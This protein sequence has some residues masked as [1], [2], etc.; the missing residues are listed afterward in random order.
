MFPA[1][2]KNKRAPACIPSNHHLAPSQSL[3]RPLRALSP[4]SASNIL[5]SREQSL[6]TARTPYAISEARFCIAAKIVCPA[7]GGLVPEVAETEHTG[8]SGQVK[9]RAGVVRNHLVSHIVELS[10]KDD[11]VFTHAIRISY[12]LQLPPADNEWAILLLQLFRLFMPLGVSSLRVATAR[13]ERKR[14]NKESQVLYQMFHAIKRIISSLPR[15]WRERGRRGL[16][17]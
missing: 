10:I 6:Q 16:I 9:K 11:A 4:Q 7:F 17:T 13:E 1:L 8:I 2:A 5:V 15:C 14:N 12:P 3:P